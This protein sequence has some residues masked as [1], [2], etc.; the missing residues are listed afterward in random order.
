MH[1]SARGMFAVLSATC[2]LHIAVLKGHEA[3]VQAL[4]D[5]GLNVDLMCSG[6]GAH[7]PS[8]LGN[9]PTRRRIVLVIT[10]L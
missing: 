2:A 4:L 8:G 9:T 1:A 7:K 10:M 5:D 3:V 6:A